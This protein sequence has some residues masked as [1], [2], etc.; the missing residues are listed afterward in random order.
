MSFTAIFIALL[1]ERFIVFNATPL[2]NWNWFGAYQRLITQKVTG[3]TPYVL[4]AAVVVPLLLGVVIV[5]LAL[6][7]LIFGFLKLIFSTAVILYCFGPRNLWVDIAICLDAM[8]E[9]DVAQLAEKLKMTFGI[10]L[11]ADTQGLHRQLLTRIFT[12]TNC[13]VF[14]LVFWFGVAGLAG[15]IVYR[16]VTLIAAEPASDDTSAALSTVARQVESYMDWPAI[17]AL[18]F[19][20]ALGGNFNRVFSSWRGKVML[21][22]ETNES[23]LIDCGMSALNSAAQETIPVDGSAEKEEVTLIDRSLAIMLV[24]LAVLVFL[25]P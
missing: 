24:I 9:G 10:N 16:L 2:R 12:Q 22:P 21:G 20:F 8:K 11:D 3:Q 6:S 13:R 25:I 17:R 18:T 15:V 23:L 19:L 4:L 1:L 14:A 5:D 7:S